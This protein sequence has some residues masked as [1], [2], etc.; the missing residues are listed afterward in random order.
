LADIGKLVAQRIDFHGKL[1]TKGGKAGILAG[2]GPVFIL[3]ARLVVQHT[4]RQS[5]PGHA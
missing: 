1:I 3:I 5:F 2:V 4:G